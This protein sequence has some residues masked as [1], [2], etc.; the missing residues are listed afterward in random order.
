[1]RPRVGN[2]AGAP[3]PNPE[4]EHGI[5]DFR[6]HAGGGVIVK[7]ADYLSAHILTLINLN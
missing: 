7:I 6:G 1:M 4:R 5:Q 2:A 3:Q